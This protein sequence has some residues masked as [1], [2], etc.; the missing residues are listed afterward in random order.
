MRDLIVQKWRPSLA[1]VIGCTLLLVMMIPFMGWIFFENFATNMSANQALLITALAALL[2]T[3]VIG[4]VLWRALLAPLTAL[5]Q[6]ARAI[7]AGEAHA[8]EPLEHYGTSE[9]RDLGQAV[10]DMGNA[11]Q[12]RERG[13]RAY[14]DHV[15]H[16]LKSPL[17][18]IIGAAE[19]LIDDE[20]SDLLANIHTSA[21]LMEKRLNGL[22]DLAKAREPLET[23]STKLSDVVPTDA[24]LIEDAQLPIASPALQAILEH[25]VQNSLAHGADE[26]KIH[27]YKDGFDI[28]DNGRGVSEGN[29]E[30]IFQPFF[31][32]KR[33]T[34]GTGMG[35][36]IVRTMLQVY[37]GD[38]ELLD[39]A[40]GAHFV[41]RFH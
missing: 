6:K 14:T 18:S 28:I 7:E 1:L 20:D 3:S 32:T 34:G 35:L 8:L 5:T 33:E 31:T 15:T 17:T 29:R 16:E 11:L 39:S 41:V 12:D 9:L 21:K 27:A 40:N 23:G 38:I 19:L 37:H 10:L 24:T 36:T 26:V 22:R 2:F 13:L 30:K 4:F 25:L